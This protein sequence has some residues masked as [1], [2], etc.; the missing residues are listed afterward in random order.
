MDNFVAAIGFGQLVQL[1]ELFPEIHG[2]Q[3]IGC[4][5]LYLLAQGHFSTSPLLLQCHPVLPVIMNARQRY[6]D[7]EHIGFVFYELLPSLMGKQRHF[8]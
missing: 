6:P 4:Q 7:D 3:S 8:M 1:L 2:L 5:W